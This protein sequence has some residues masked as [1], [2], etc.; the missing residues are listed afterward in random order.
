VKIRRAVRKDQ[1]SI[2]KLYNLLYPHKKKK[3]LPL[4]SRI[5]SLIYLADV[6]K[7][8]VGFIWA[9]FIQYGISRFGYIDELFVK[10]E[11]RNQGIGRRLVRIVLKDL[12]KMNTDAVFVTTEKQARTAIDMYKKVGFKKCKGLWFYYKGK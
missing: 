1:K 5:K 12:K 2:S 6:N 8:V 3:L 4:K 9:N 11:F 10:K 7:Q